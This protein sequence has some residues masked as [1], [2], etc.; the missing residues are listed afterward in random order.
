MAAT[1]SLSMALSQEELFVILAH[2]KAERLLGLE[3]E[4]LK[5]LSGDQIS[6]VMGVAER[7]LMARGF[8]KPGPE[9]RLQLEPPVFAA[10]G[11]CAFPETSLIVTRHRPDAVGENYFFHTSRKMIVMHTMPV[12]A[13]ISL[14]VEENC[15][16]QN[17]TRF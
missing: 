7:A 13:F 16:C 1:T 11:A 2:L 15:N 5:G 12:T 8:L 6:L 9:N 4:I 14:A 10:V 3:S 17:R